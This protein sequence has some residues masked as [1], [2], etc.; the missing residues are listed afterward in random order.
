MRLKLQNVVIVLAVTALSSC[1][2]CGN[3][4]TQSIVSPSGKVKAVVFTRDCG[5]TTGFS[6][7]I[8]IIRAS[9]TLPNLAGNALVLN[10]KVRLHLRWRSDVLLEV[11]G[12]GNHEVF[13][14]KEKVAGVS[15]QYS[16]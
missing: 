11:T 4:V 14:E 15:L 3:D 12:L 5:A 2:L 16:K 13:K 7:Q 10:N 6:T 8:S 9:E 1:G